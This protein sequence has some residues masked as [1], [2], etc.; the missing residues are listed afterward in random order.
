MELVGE[1]HS[2]IEST[3]KLLKEKL[4]QNPNL[5]SF[6]FVLAD[7]QTSGRGRADHTWDSVAGNLHVSILLKDAP[8][9]CLTWIPLWVSVCVHQTLIELEVDS[10]A[11]QL[12]WPNDIWVNHAKKAGGILCEKVGS[13][14]IVGI[15]L[16]LIQAPHP[17]SAVIPFSK[18]INRDHFLTLLVLKLKQPLFV[19]AVRTYY[20]RFALF[21]KNE[22]VNWREDSTGRQFSGEIVG[23]GEYGELLVKSEEKVISLYSETV[24]SVRSI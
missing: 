8:V 12:K 19:P 6:Y 16:N 15:G 7:V 17:D 2:S 5:E 18:K 3:Q 23:L 13:S 14:L 9:D 24:N 22:K 21:A 10:A 1:K 20:E 4:K 11:I